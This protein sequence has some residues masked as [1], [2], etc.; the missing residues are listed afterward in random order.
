MFKLTY[1]EIA[2]HVIYNKTKRILAVFRRARLNNT[3]FT[4]VSNNCWGGICYEHF[5][6]KKKSPTIGTFFFAEDYIRFISNFE[7]YVNCDIQIASSAKSKHYEWLKQHGCDEA[8]VGILDDVEICFLHYKDPTLAKDKWTRR[9]SR[10]NRDNLIFKFSYMNDCTD[11]HLK[12]FDSMNLPG[13][14]FMFVKDKNH[15]YKSGVYYP[16]FDDDEQITNDTYFWNRYF[17]VVKFI[18][19]GEIHLKNAKVGDY[20]KL[21]KK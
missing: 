17:D 18:N 14:K 9:V 13:K 4:I 15:S 21:W 6:L 12:K 20:D 1:R 3:D 16:G 7:Y 11:E 2:K 19:T 5:G 8:L 10:I